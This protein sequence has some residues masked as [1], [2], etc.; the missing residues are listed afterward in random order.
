V[1]EHQVIEDAREMLRLADDERKSR[2][3]NYFKAL[4]EI[5]AHINFS[6]RFLLPDFSNVWDVIEKFDG[7]KMFMFLA[8]SLR[9]PYKNCWFEYHY[10]L[11]GGFAK[12]RALLVSELR[13][14]AMCLLL[15][16][17]FR[18]HENQ[19]PRWFLG[20]LWYLVSIGKALPDTITAAEFYRFTGV[21]WDVVAPM[22]SEKNIF[23]CPLAEL[24]RQEYFRIF[25]ADKTDLCVL[26]AALLLLNCKN[27]VQ[28]E[29]RPD[30]KANKARARKGK[31]ELLSYH[32]LKILVPGNRQ[33]TTSGG[34]SNSANRIHFCRGHFK[35][36]TAEKPLLG[37][38]TG[39][40]WWSPH[41]RGR[42]KNG[43]VLKDYQMEAKK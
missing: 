43:M 38:H 6:Q 11:P 21:S 28:E 26:N 2:D 3:S 35:E 40:Y 33:S 34:E 41:I 17:K 36:Y 39:L 20:P 19:L 16:Q 15:F 7:K 22:F 8:E 13:P 4:R 9:L 37:K 10:D 30:K 1:F 27:I 31:T 29:V 42:N 25:E 23:P 14:G 24:N 18:A 32:V 12:K 5:E